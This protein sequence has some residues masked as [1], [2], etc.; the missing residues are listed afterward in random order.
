MGF[1]APACVWAAAGC[2]RASD[3][4]PGNL[5]VSPQPR[6]CQTREA[7]LQDVRL[8]RL[9][10][11][12]L[13]GLLGRDPWAGGYEPPRQIG[14]SPSCPSQGLGQASFFTNSELLAEGPCQEA[15]E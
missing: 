10:G 1:V 6:H 2:L 5:W 9:V 7:N 13:D 11:H 15:V 12:L 14:V 3:S 8:G 4:F